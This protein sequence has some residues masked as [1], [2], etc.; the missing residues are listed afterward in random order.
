MKQ[1][2]RLLLT[3]IVGKNKNVSILKSNLD[4]LNSVRVCVCVCVCFNRI[5]D[6]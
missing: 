4:Y 1:I 6:D 5:H 3:I 2:N